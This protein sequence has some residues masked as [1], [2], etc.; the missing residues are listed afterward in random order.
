MVADCP[1][2][3]LLEAFLDGRGSEQLVE[4]VAECSS[5]AERM[6]SL[7]EL[8]RDRI[9][10]AT[11]RDQPHQYLN[12]QKY[13][14]LKQW[15]R[16]FR[17]NSSARVPADISETI[18]RYQVRRFL[19]KGSF[20]D[21]YAA[22]DPLFDIERA[23]K[24]LRR[25]LFNSESSRNQFLAEARHAVKVS[26]PGL[27]DVRDVVIDPDQSFIVMKLIDGET[28]EKRLRRGPVEIATTV[29]IMTK[30]AQAANHAHEAGLVHR[31]LKP[32][33]ILLDQHENPVIADFGLVID[34]KDL[35]EVDRSASFA[36]TRP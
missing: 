15:T 9:F 34:Q 30:A 25:G 6:K 26:H 16:F 21:V 12:E 4:H 33:N 3:E 18:G 5:C 22:E 20:G 31:D 35:S 19:G 10:A 23:V 1:D 17:V 7:L 32:A 11:T 14:D 8:E 13:E 29:Q 36:G 27:V 2:V 28:L 24:L